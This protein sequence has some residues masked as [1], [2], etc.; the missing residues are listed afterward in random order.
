MKIII[1]CLLVLIL[2]SI[3]TSAQ[4]SFFAESQSYASKSI[5]SPFEFVWANKYF[6]STNWGIFLFAAATNRWGEL[7]MGPSYTFKSIKNP[8]SFLEVGAG[9]GIESADRPHREAVYAFFNLNPDSSGKKN[10][11]KVVGLLNAEYG[12]SGYWYL[13]FVVKSISEKIAIGV[14][15]QSFTGV[16]GPRFQYQPSSLMLYVVPGYSLER[17]E[18][19]VTAAV[20]YYF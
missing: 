1:S 6:D 9:F 16:W 18:Y 3:K 13:G 11:G 19:G 20:R 5:Y 12:G 2:M 17:K 4:T 15:A 14:H 8:Q 10:K 7:Y